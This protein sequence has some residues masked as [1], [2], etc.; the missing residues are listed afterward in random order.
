[1]T[2][3]EEFTLRARRHMDMIFRVAYGYL[4]NSFDADDVTQN[5]LLKLYSEKQEFTSEE[6]LKHWLIRVTVNQC[7]N[8]F[9]APWH[10][11]ESIDDYAA[12]LGFETTE[13]TDLFLTVMAMDK[14]YRIPL[15]LY[16]YEGYSMEEI[17]KLLSMPVKTVGTR[18]RR[19]RQQ[20][21]DQ[22][23]EVV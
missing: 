10:N 6:H 2:H 21:K 12:A 18:L 5:V 15:L 13:Q 1:M 19:G 11:Q 23:T 3:D 22:L 9:R 20:L 16:Y 17:S 4:K 7:K 14:K 8:V